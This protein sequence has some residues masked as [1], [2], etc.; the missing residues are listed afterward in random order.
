MS[1]MPGVEFLEA[2][3]GRVQ[4]AIAAIDAGALERLATR[5]DE[6]VSNGGHVFYIGNGGSASTATHYVND[7]V[8]AYA[9]TNR[10]VRAVSLTDNPSL[11]TGISNDYSFDEVFAYQLRALSRP[12]DMVVAISASGNSRNLV[13]AFEFAHDAGLAT[14]AVVGFDGGKLKDMADV[15]VHAPTEMGDYGPAEDVH[16]MINHAVA[17]LIRA[18]GE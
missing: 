11:V 15:V 2:Y 13:R 14:A 18:R 7:L 8:M 6:T 16:L 10:V 9:R 3:L 5:I 1:D 17:G 4:T 12:G